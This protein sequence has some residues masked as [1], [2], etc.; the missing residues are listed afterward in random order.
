MSSNCEVVH[1]GPGTGKIDYCEHDFAHLFLTLGFQHNCTFED[2]VHPYA[3]VL[4]PDALLLQILMNSLNSK[5]KLM[6]FLAFRVSVHYKEMHAQNG[7]K[8]L[9]RKLTKLLI[10]N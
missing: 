5:M 7:V 3:W 2:H 4:S 1:Q 6:A 8:K 10:K 9:L